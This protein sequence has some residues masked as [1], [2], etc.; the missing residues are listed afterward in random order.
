MSTHGEKRVQG[1]YPNATVKRVACCC[2]R[3]FVWSSGRC[4]DGNC[5]GAVFTTRLDGE[6]QIRAG[7]PWIPYSATENSVNPLSPSALGC[8]GRSV[9]CWPRSATGWTDWISPFHNRAQRHTQSCELEVDDHAKSQPLSFLTYKPFK[10][11]HELL[12][13]W[14]FSL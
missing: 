4:R 13:F 9:C 6:C 12:F 8:K 5:R 10:L 14:R 3:S 11:T 1:M 7:I 2:H